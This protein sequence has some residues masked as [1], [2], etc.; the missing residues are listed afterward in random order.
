[1][2]Y[3][4]MGNRSGVTDAVGHATTYGFDVMNRIHQVTQPEAAITSYTYDSQ[5]NLK[6][7]TD[8]E[9]HVTSYT[10]D[11]M[12]NL[13]TEISPDTGSKEHRYDL[14]SNRTGSTDANGVSITYGFDLLNRLTAIS[15]P[16]AAQNITYTYDQG[17]SGKG[18]LTAIGD[19]PAAP[20]WNT[21]TTAIW[22]RRPGSSAP[23]PSS[24]PMPITTTT[25]WRK[26]PIPAAELSVMSVMLPERSPRWR[27]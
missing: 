18:R 5:D 16:D 17:M 23:R 14:N 11:D 20:P 25:S 4:D 12:G 3:D 24:P 15:F 21:T 1:M 6:T 7:V 13:L 10:F 22:P 9:G 2:A 19:P 8:A 27:M 26:S